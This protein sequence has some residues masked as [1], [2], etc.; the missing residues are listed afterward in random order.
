MK[1]KA[2]TDPDK[3]SALGRAL[4]ESRRGDAH[5]V[6]HAQL[7][8]ALIRCIEAGHWGPGERLPTEADLIAL[9]GLSLGTVQRALRSLVEEGVVKRRQGSG[10]YVS[11]PQQR[12]GDL[13]IARFQ[14]DDG[15]DLLPVYSRVIA[16][17][18]VARTPALARHFPDVAAR[19]LRIDRSLNVNGE[20]EVASRFYFDGGR[21]IGLANAPLGDLAGANFKALLGQESPLPAGEML[22]TAQVVAAPRPIARRLGIGHPAI[23]CLLEIIRTD[24]VRGQVV[25]F[26]QMFIPASDRKLRLLP[27]A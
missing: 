22:Q 26:Q 27:P 16:R 10:S 11:D 17:R 23:V 15:D 24:A 5:Q 14:G 18:A 7:R 9:S 21:Y 19:I 13:A 6:R 25:F 8:A 2:N 3:A 12:V 4:A 1:T 20:F